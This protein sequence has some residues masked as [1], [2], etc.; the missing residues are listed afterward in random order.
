MVEG[1][2]CGLIDGKGAKV[3]RLRVLTPADMPRWLANASSSA[4]NWAKATN[5]SAK[6]GTISLLPDGRGQVAEILLGLGEE[7]DFRAFAALPGL[8][9][10]GM[11]VE[12]FNPLPEE[13][14]NRAALEWALG[15]YVFRRYKKNGKPQPEAQLVWP[16]EADRPWVRRAVNGIF[17]VRDLVNT[18]AADLGPDELEEAA[19]ALARKYNGKISVITGTELARKNYPAIYAVGKGSARAPRLIDISFGRK[20]DPKVTLVGKGVCFDS[21]GYDIKPASAMKLMK[22]DMGGAAHVLALA[23]MIRE[24]RLPLRLRVLIPAVENLISGEAFKP[25]DIINTRKGITVEIGDTDAEGRLILA[26]ALTEADSE[27]PALLLDFATLTGAARAA[28]GPDLPALFANSDRLAEDFLKAG[29][30]IDDPLWRLPLWAP[31]RRL[32]ESKLADISSTGDSAH[33]GAITAALFLERFVSK[34]TP[35]AHLDIFAWNGG[36]RPGRPEGGEA[37]GLLA[38]YELIVNRLSA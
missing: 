17:L 10:P 12:C 34:S 23:G 35:W 11:A 37:M 32:L 4:A 14:A 20:N 21:G 2:F 29:Q 24:A 18:P 19:R 33:A 3:V 5:F 13:A 31:Y 36:N 8:L 9:P 1:A 22:K 26:D 30:G 6:S 38:A 27:S 28:L 25:L 7:R 15:T 16:E